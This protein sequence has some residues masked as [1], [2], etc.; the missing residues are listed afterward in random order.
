[1]RTWVRYLLFQIPGWL[2]AAVVLYALR[3]QIGLPVK[4][5]AGLFF[6]WVVKDLVLYPLL[7][8]SYERTTKTGTEQLVD[9]RGVAQNRIDPRGHIRVRGEIWSAEVEP[10]GAAIAAGT[11]V[12]I[13]AAERMTLIVEADTTASEGRP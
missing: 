13:L 11:N 1:M 10:G 9:L 12:R 2:I 8:R 4:L 5:A 3:Y 7:R 6:L